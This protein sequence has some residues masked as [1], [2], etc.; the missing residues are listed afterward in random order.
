M[1]PRGFDRGVRAPDEQG[2]LVLG[3]RCFEVTCVRGNGLAQLGAVVHREV[4]ALPVGRVQ[5]R[6]VSVDRIGRQVQ[7][8]GVSGSAEFTAASAL[9]SYS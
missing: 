7:A 2:L 5:V 3:E 8:L 1:D 6:G 4:R 9:L